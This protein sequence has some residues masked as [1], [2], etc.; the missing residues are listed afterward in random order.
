MNVLLRLALQLSA[1]S[2]SWN[3][4]FSRVEAKLHTLFSFYGSF[5]SEFHESA[6]A[7][8]VERQIRLSPPYLRRAESHH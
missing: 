7:E 1:I 3:E 4:L 8:P 5:E 6:V 2:D